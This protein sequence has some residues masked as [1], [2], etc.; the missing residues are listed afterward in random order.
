MGRGREVPAGRRRGERPLAREEHRSAARSAAS[1]RAERTFGRLAGDGVSVPLWATILAATALLA[2]I[3]V[4]QP[5]RGYLSQRAQYDAIVDQL[6]QAQATSTALEDQLAQWQDDDYVR[7]QAR[8]RLFYVMPGETTYVV[9]GADELEESGHADAQTGP[10]AA[11]PW[12]KVL[13]RSA[14]VAGGVRPDPAAQDGATTAPEV[15]QPAG[16]E[17]TDTT[18]PA[19]AQDDE[20]D[21]AQDGAASG[22][23]DAA[24]DDG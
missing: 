4:F 9:V 10:E 24:N 12:F 3:V 17:A 5:L 21:G 22:T 13:R 18:D 15:R 20:P 16:T 2:L 14:E 7:S 19:D 23:S 11:L 6:A 1:G 8:Q